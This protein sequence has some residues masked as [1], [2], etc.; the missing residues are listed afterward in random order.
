MNKKNQPIRGKNHWTEVRIKVG[1]PVYQP[2][3]VSLWVFAQRLRF[4]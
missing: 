4:A 2:G 1:G 3:T